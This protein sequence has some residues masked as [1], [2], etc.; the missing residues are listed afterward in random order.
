M[1]FLLAA[2]ALAAAF[3]GRRA[4]AY[5]HVEKIY[6]VNIGSWLL[7]EPWMLPK[8]AYLPPVCRQEHEV[9]DLAV[10]RVGGDW[11]TAELHGLLG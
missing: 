3:I 6:G 2:G 10:D 4:A 8:G 9:T 11:R 7:V 1:R 5:P